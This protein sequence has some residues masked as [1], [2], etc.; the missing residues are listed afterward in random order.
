MATDS[1]AEPGSFDLRRVS[2]ALLVCAFGLLLMLAAWRAGPPQWRAAR[3]LATLSATAHGEVD[4]LWWHLDFDPRPLGRDGTN[5]LALTAPELCARLRFRPAGT[6][7]EQKAVACRRWSE[8]RDVRQLLAPE[9]AP[10]LPASFA[11]A[12][13]R[14]VIDIRLSARALAW[15]SAHPPAVFWVHPDVA[16]DVVP[17][18]HSELE[19]L[20]WVIDDA[21]RKLADTAT[22]RST[23][24]EVA[25]DP[26][27]PR[28]AAP[29]A[30]RRDPLLHSPIERIFPVLAFVAG[31]VAWCAG[32]F[33]LLTPRAR[34]LGFAIA[35]TGGLTV[36]LWGE[37]AA[38]LLRDVVPAVGGFVDSLTQA[39]VPSAPRPILRD[40]DSVGEPGERRRPWLAPPAT[41]SDL[42]TG[43][44]DRVAA[45]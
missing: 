33:L 11:A 22:G 20:A 27:D 41:R 9:L 38:F 23:A 39:L 10:D 36:P 15:L 1:P 12:N 17:T 43:M 13:G 26:A 19:L 35:L 5:W 24:I 6:G 42:R 25:Y 30:W 45:R 40:P 37:P 29:A 7:E 18:L 44:E 3:R 31:L 34:R 21:E 32:G 16:F 14:P 2:G 28:R 8:L 4:A